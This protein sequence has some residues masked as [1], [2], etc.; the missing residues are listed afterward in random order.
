MKLGMQKLGLNTLSD[1]ISNAELFGALSE[2]TE[3]TL[4]AP[5]DVSIQDL[6]STQ[7][8]VA[9]RL[10]DKAA[11]KNLL[12]NHAALGKI[13]ASD[14]EDG[15]QVKNLA[16][17]YLEIKVDEDGVRVGG[18]MVRKAD[19]PVLNM[20]VHELA[21][22]ILP[23]QLQDDSHM[24]DQ[25]HQILADLHDEMDVKAEGGNDSEAE[26]ELDAESESA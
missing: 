1:M 9:K 24:L 7:P 26:S 5:T 22:V 17:K 6:L 13:M 12:L 16:N 14:I 23:E 15:M 4:F 3:I 8:Q 19:I 11:L 21:S 25:D 20:I 2:D 10:E 18:A